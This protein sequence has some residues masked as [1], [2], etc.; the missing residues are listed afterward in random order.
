MYARRGDSV[1]F[2]PMGITKKRY[3]I[4]NSPVHLSRAFG[5]YSDLNIGTSTSIS[6]LKITTSFATLK[7]IISQ[8][9]IDF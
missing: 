9:K 3:A 5:V 1:A 8:K 2:V 7:K 4:L 6:L